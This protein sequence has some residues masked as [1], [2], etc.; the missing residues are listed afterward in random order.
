MAFYRVFTGVACGSGNVGQAIR[1]SDIDT[2]MNRRNVSRT[3]KKDAQCPL[4]RESRVRLK[5]PNADS[6]FFVQF[7]RH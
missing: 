3:R 7:A 6:W 1:P 2:L 4:Y 5:S